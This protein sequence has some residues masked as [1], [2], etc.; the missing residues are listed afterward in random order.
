MA[1]ARQ[2]ALV[3][4]C[5]LAIGEGCGGHDSGGSA[6]GAEGDV[7]AGK[8]D[9]Q[10]MCASCHG[11]LGEGSLGPRLKP[12]TKGADKLHALLGATMPK[13][14]PSQCD[15]KCADDVTAYILSWSSGVTANFAPRRLRLLNRREY[16]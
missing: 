11:S 5:A 16:N 6:A 1:M 15:A 4:A 7:G 10:A 8:S 13:G 9:Y 12:W 3:L 2:T 14:N